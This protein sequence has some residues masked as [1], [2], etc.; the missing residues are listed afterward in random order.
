M[1]LDSNIHYDTQSIKRKLVLV[2]AQLK[3]MRQEIDDIKA[4][5]FSMVYMLKSID[6]RLSMLTLHPDVPVIKEKR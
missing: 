4:L 1:S 5:Q 3:S 6:Q 2:D